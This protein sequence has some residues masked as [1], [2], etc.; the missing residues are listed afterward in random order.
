MLLLSPL[1]LRQLQFVPVGSLYSVPVPNDPAIVG[2][3]V[4]IQ[5]FV[6]DAVDPLLS[7]M[8]NLE[9]LIIGA[10]LP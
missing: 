6:V 8:T 4:G 2:F 5:A 3:D 9:R 10:Q 7:Q 1:N